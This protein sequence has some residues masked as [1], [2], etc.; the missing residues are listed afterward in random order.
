MLKTD[1][2]NGVRASITANTKLELFFE[3]V[4]LLDKARISKADAQQFK[5]DIASLVKTTTNELLTGIKDLLISRQTSSDG[6]DHSAANDEFDTVNGMRAVIEQ[7]LVVNGIQTENA[8]Q[9]LDDL[10]PH[11]LNETLTRCKLVLTHRKAIRAYNQTDLLIEFSIK[12]H[13]EENLTNVIAEALKKGG[14]T[15]QKAKT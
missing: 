15:L 12:C 10:E 11:V 6:T 2:E 5:D 7:M 9:Y 14:C 1:S 3:M 8:K 4:E 13:E